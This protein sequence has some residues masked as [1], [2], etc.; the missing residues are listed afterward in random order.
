M[1]TFTLIAG[2]KD[3]L[4]AAQVVQALATDKGWSIEI[5]EFK[6]R[7]SDQ[8]NRY[9]W[10]SVY[11]QFLT[12]GGEALAGWEASDLHEF[13]LGEC[14][15]W[16]LLEGF[17]RKRVKPVRRSGKLNKTEFTA[18]VDFIQRKAAGMGIYIEDPQEVL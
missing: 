11:P 9:L 4:R 1:Q 14:F 18:Y 16:E 17:G 15:G 2:R 13:L 6:P 10:G 7:R 3:S 8:Q 5:K 12:G